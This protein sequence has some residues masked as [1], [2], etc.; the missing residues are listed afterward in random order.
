MTKFRMGIGMCAVGDGNELI[1][2]GRIEMHGSF[3][4]GMEASGIEN[5]ELAGADV[6][7]ANEGRI[8]VQG[9]LS[10]GVTLGLTL[11]YSY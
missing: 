11:A 7:I 5:Q 3:S 8:L 4:I 6:R 1:N 10:M 9:D 2:R